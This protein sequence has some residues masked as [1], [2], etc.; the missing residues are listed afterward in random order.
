MSSRQKLME[1]LHYFEGATE[2]VVKSHVTWADADMAFAV[3]RSELDKLFGQSD[4]LAVPI[5]RQA[6]A[7]GQL[8]A[9]DYGRHLA[10]YACLKE[11]ISTAKTV[12]NEADLDRSDLI[13][14]IIQGRLGHM[15]QK[16]L[17]FLHQRQN[18]KYIDLYKK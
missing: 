5:L 10:L 17:D 7:G 18:R 1:L 4:K 9:N 8:K 16:L 6:T 2:R 15:S 14:D 12:E 11:A 13:N 3:V